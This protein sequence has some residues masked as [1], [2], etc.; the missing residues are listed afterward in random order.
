MDAWLLV[1]ERQIAATP[2][3]AAFSAPGIVGARGAALTPRG[4]GA[5]QFN[6]GKPGAVNP[7]SVNPATVNRG[8][9]V[10]KPGAPKPP[11]KK[12]PPPQRREPER[13]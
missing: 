3:P 11:P 13:N 10:Q 5:G 1:L 4:P 6:G 12:A 8:Q 9:S 2:R 7:G